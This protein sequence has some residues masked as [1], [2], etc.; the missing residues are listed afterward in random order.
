ME[1]NALIPSIRKGRKHYRLFTLITVCFTLLTALSACAFLP[2][3]A[4]DS[5][6]PTASP[7]VNVTEDGLMDLFRTGDT[8]YYTTGQGRLFLL[9]ETDSALVKEF[10]VKDLFWSEDFEAFLYY[11]EGTVFSWKPENDATYVLAEGLPKG[12]N[13]YFIAQVK[14]DFFF[15]VD[16]AVYRYC[17]RT[18]ELIDEEIEV[19]HTIA[20]NERYYLYEKNDNIVCIDSETGQ[21]KEVAAL[22]PAQS[23]TCACIDGDTL[24]YVSDFKLQSAA[25]AAGA[26]DG[27]ERILHLSKY[28][29]IQAIAC[30]E[31][32]LVFITESS[33]PENNSRL[34]KAM[35]CEKDGTVTTLREAAEPA[36]TIP[37]SCR[38]IVSE[39]QYCYGVKSDPAVIIGDLP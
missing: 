5:T 37:G 7:G 4:S 28:K 26:D 11:Y 18:G 16:N 31:K 6:K 14:Q 29:Y 17:L 35:L 33:A 3:S 13:A 36:F 23:V 8:F 12:K 38:L 19:C 15:W 24:F 32:G 34:T 20:C 1:K 39:N 2:E 9:T 30:C 25:L 21:R 22:E 27:A 10:P